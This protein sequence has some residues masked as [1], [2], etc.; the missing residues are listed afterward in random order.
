M[1]TQ[2]K[3]ERQHASPQQGQVV[4]DDALRHL[5]L[6][7]QPAQIDLLCWVLDLINEVV[8]AQND[9]PSHQRAVSC[10]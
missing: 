8:A 10:L 6:I 1:I 5:V 3:T 9:L 7:L 4:A 2:H